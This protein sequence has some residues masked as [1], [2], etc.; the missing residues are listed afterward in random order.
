MKA[1]PLPPLNVLEHLFQIDKASPSGLI[2]LNPTNSKQK[3]MSIARHKR[4]N[5]YWYVSVNYAQVLVHRIVYYLHHKIN[6]DEYM[7]DH[8][9]QDSTNNNIDNLRIA[10]HQQQQCNKKG[11]QNSTSKYKGVSWC[12]VLS[13]WK[14]SICVNCKRMHIG[15]Y[16]TEK[17]AALAYNKKANQLHSSFAFLNDV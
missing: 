4:K 5:Q 9:D 15:Y 11:K 10:N 16:E 7:I 6:I 8:I 2:W 14:A 12:K 17:E 13:K 1:K 3:P